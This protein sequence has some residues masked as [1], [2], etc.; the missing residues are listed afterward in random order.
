MG[1]FQGL[2]ILD[3]DAVTRGDTGAGHD[4]RRRGQA[5]CARASDDQHGH[6]IDDSRFDG[7]T[8]EPPAQH[9]GQR[10]QQYHRNEDLADPVH[11][12]LDRRLAGL[13]VLDQADDSCQDRLGAQRL[14]AHQQPGFPVDCTTCDFVAGLLGYGQAFAADQRFIGM[15]LAFDDFT[16]DRE[17]LTGLDQ[18]QVVQLQ[19][20]DRHFLF[21]TVDYLHRAFGAQ[22]FEGA[23]GTGGLALGA[24]FQ[25]FAEQDQR[26]D[27]CR[28]FE[29][30]MGHFTC[31]GAGPFIK[32]EA[33]T[34]AG[35]DGHQQVHITGASLDRFP[36]RDV[37]ARTQ[38]ELHG[39]CQHELRPGRQHP[40]NAQWLQQHG[41][42]QWQRQGNGQ[43]QGPALIAQASFNV[44]TGRTSR[45]G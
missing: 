34:G 14:G 44:I 15:A 22:G 2:G 32:A 9:G 42:Y 3:Q 8:T 26:D 10:Q 12:L 43:A 6:G 35:A 24:A 29:V 20:T 23:D 16:V 1:V 11:Q 27:H 38:N 25:V 40:V 17:T 4:C 41:Q 39:R 5:Q 21:A 31:A 36:G 28:G 45:V 37:E 18:Y 7:G 30:Q 19:C 33:I 13:G